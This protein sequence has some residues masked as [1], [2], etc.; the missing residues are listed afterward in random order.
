MRN[1]QKSFLVLVIVAAFAI[2]ALG[3][4]SSGSLSGSVVDPKGAVVANATVTVKN[5]ATNQE[6]TT[7]TSDDGT[8]SVPALS[9]GMYTAIIT[10][11]GFKQAVVTEIKIDVGKTSSIQVEL[12]VGAATETVTIV[13]GGEL[14]QTQ[15]AT[16]GTTLTGRQITD[17][18]T[19]SRDALDLVLAMPGTTTVGR[20]RQSSVNGLPKGAINITL[21]GINVQDNLLKSNDGFFTYVRP[22]TD[23][24]SEVTVSTA[25][26]GAESSSEGAVQIKF[27]TQGGTNDYHGG[28]YWY[29]RNPALNANYWFNNRDQAPDPVTKKAPQARILLNQPGGKFGGP[30]RIPKLFDGTDK[31]FF[32]VNYEEYRLPERTSRT[33]NILHPLAQAGNYRWFS[34]SDLTSSA[35]FTSCA[36]APSG[37]PA[38]FL[39]SMNVFSK[40]GSVADCNRAVSGNQPCL[41]TPDPTVGSLLSNIRSSVNGFVIKDAGDPNIQQVSFVNPGGQVRKFP[42]VRF[43]FN[44]GKNHHIENVWNYQQFR[45]SVDFL[46][47]VDPSFPGFPNTGSQDS[48]RFSNSTAWR[49]TI[50]QNLVNEMRYGVL[51]GTSLFFAGVNATQFENQGGYNLG[52][53]NFASGGFTLT[54]AT[55]TAAPSRRHTP[56]RQ[57]NNNL[58]WVTGNHSLSFGGNFTKITYWNQALTVVKSAVFTT[59]QTLDPGGFDAFSGLPATQQGGAAQLYYLLSGRLTAVNANARLNEDT[60]KYSF[61]GDLESR[62]GQK[63]YGI[64]AQDSWRLTPALTLNAGLRWEVQLPF[65]GLNNTFAT[66]PL[67]GLYGESG[68]GN[69]FKP[70]TLTGATSNYVSFGKGYKTYKADYGNFA[71]TVGIAWSPNFENGILRRLSGNAGQT[72]I[73]AGYSV[74]FNREGVGVFTAVTGG[75]P[76]GTLTANRNLTLGNLPV[77]T[78]LRQ[79][80]FAPPSFP[81]EP[82][83]PNT[84]LITDAV[85][86]FSPNL[87]VGKIHSWSFGIQRELNADTVL[88]V[89]YIGNRGRDLWRQYDLNELNII[90]N[91]VFAEWQLAQRNLIANILANRCQPGLSPIKGEPGFTPGCQANFAYFGNGTGT[92]PLPITLGYFQG[93][94]GTAVTNAA[95]YTNANFRSSTYYNTMNPLNPAPLTFGNNLSSTSFDNRRTGAG[96]LFPYNHFLVNPGK[97]G[98]AFIVDNSGESFYDAATIELRRRLSAGLLIQANYTFGKAIANTYASSSSVFDQPNTLRNPDLRRGVAPFDITHSFKANFIY[99]LPVGQGKKFFSGSR[100]IINGLIGGWG[101]NGNIRMQSGSPF[102]LGNVQLVGMDAKELQ[103]QVGVYRDPDGFIYVF[104]KDIRDNTVKAHNLAVQIFTPSNSA[105]NGTLSTATITYTQGAPSGRFIA[106][107]GFGNCQQSFGHVPSLNAPLIGGGCGFTI[108]VL[109]GPA[110]FRSDLSLVKKVRFNERMNLELRGEFL[111]A[112][113]NINFLVGS[114]GNDLNT[115][116]GFTSSAFGRMT[117]AYQDLSTTN[118]PGGRLVQLV[119]RFNF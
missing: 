4:G 109:K 113:N 92:F 112:F 84:G 72:V 23:A 41:T 18:P 40:A 61:L 93:L 110:F 90:E 57:F 3:Q 78:Y 87:K 68:L 32:F 38:A 15:T 97:R 12:E 20:P 5:I 33:R 104:P 111:N 96:A 8:F 9:T 28:L 98:G 118:D 17:L 106:P 77:G 119:V 49:W 69:L 103:K 76:G 52:L 62:A 54:S 88:E 16:I 25:T 34:A 55:A 45:S 73:R 21:D 108:L 114:A 43:D 71:P 36:S 30:I 99:E 85:N 10:A 91:G 37:S 24:I 1:V 64:F 11:S 14:L 22:R 75:N 81:S 117:N 67:E 7:K 63:E 101:F 6:N 26:P 59:S 60:L 53:G 102:S 80:P 95:N 44:V 86:A 94:S 35:T 89:R 51:G 58:N 39:C 79:G 42:T 116:G 13:G 65:E 82:V 2:T 100:G 46:N 50:S 107:A 19:A 74:A 70:G 115:L 56:V 31:A 29:H 27:A 105:P 47:G 66:V 83:Y 48:N